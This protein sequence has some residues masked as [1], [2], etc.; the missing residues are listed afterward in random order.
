M[1]KAVTKLTPED[2]QKYP[3]WEY[4][5]GKSDKNGD[6]IVKSVEALPVADLSNRYV[7]G[8]P[9]RLANGNQVWAALENIQT[10][11]PHKTQHV[12][13]LTIE[14]DGKWFHLARYFDPWYDKENPEALSKFLGLPIDDIFPISY[15]VQPYV[16]MDS[17]AHAGQIPREPKERLPSDLVLKLAD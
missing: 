1:K 15:D 2:F 12:I 10:A 5:W 14:K 13:C 4:Q 16:A 11:K 3:V 17:P 6:T 7:V 9:V 8:V